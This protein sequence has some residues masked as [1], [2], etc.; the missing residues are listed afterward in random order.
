M[1]NIQRQTENNPNIPYQSIKNTAKTTGLSEY[2]IRQR[3]H[4]G[5]LPHIKSGS[6]VL[7]NV[8]KFLK[9]LEEEEENG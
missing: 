5:T 9:Q 7:V 4:N 1:L 3:L 6:K 8:P 2:S